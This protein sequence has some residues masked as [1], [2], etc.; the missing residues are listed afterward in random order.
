M[1]YEGVLKVIRFE[2]GRAGDQADEM[3]VLTIHDDSNTTVEL[4]F[5]ASAVGGFYIGEAVRI[6]VG[7]QTIVI[8]HR[9][10]PEGR[11]ETD[12]WF[13]VGKACAARG[14]RRVLRSFVNRMRVD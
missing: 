14:A 3:A 5:Q 11:P 6:K 9:H 13:F 1:I 10:P 4:R 2:A 8:T 7:P 12:I